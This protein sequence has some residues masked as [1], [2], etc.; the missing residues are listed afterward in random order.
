M[1]QPPESTTQS[2]LKDPG[3]DAVPGASQ[4]PE[5]TTQPDLKDP[6][7]VAPGTASATLATSGAAPDAF[8]PA[9]PTDNRSLYEHASKWSPEAITGHRREGRWLA[10]LGTIGLVGLFALL[11]FTPVVQ[12]PQTVTSM[13]LVWCAGL[14]GGTVFS[15]KWLYH[16]IAKGIWN[17]DR[18]AWRIAV[19]LQAAVVSMFMHVLFKS[20]LLGILNPAAM[21]KIHNILAFGFLVG[22]FSDS[23]V[24]KLAEIAESLF[25]T[26]RGSR[27]KANR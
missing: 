25:G 11:I 8:A 18:F 24:A 14:L 2:D 20:D 15:L 4:P 26:S 12:C 7:C 22:Y 5:S 3:A 19:P 9:N 10:V 23:A 21:D 13:A 6:G 17:L 27:G 1:T 16:S